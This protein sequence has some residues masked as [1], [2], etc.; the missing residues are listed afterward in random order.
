MLT[1]NPAS[2]EAVGATTAELKFF[3]MMPGVTGTCPAGTHPIIHLYHPTYKTHF[4]TTSV[5][6]RDAMKRTGWRVAIQGTDPGLLNACI[7]AKDETSCD[8]LPLMRVTAAGDPTQWMNATTSVREVRDCL[9]TV[10]VSPATKSCSYKPASND[11]LGRVW[12]KP[13]AYVV[14]Q[15]LDMTG[16]K[17]I[18][19]TLGGGTATAVARTSGGIDEVHPIP[20]PADFAFSYQGVPIKYY[21]KASSN[22]LI[23]FNQPFMDKDDSLADPHDLPA[24]KPPFRQVSGWWEPS[25]LVND[26]TLLWEMQGTAPNRRLV[27][28]WGSPKEGGWWYTRDRSTAREMQIHLVESSNRI[29]VHYGEM[30]TVPGSTASAAVGMDDVF[31]VDG[32]QTACS[33]H[34]GVSDWKLEG[35]TAFMPS[36]R[37]FGAFEEWPVSPDTTFPWLTD[38]TPGVH[39]EMTGAKGLGA[40]PLGGNFPFDGQIFQTV[41]IATSGHLRLGKTATLDSH[42]DIPPDPADRGIA[43]N[44]IA[45]W[46][47]ENLR[48]G[49]D[50]RGIK[51]DILTLQIDK[52]PDGPEFVV[53]W[54]NL[55]NVNDTLPTPAT[56]QMQVRLRATDGSIIFRYG[57]SSFV[58]PGT[59]GILPLLVDR[60]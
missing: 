56:R 41:S 54:N 29:E 51:G 42:A 35:V 6:E 58:N 11:T 10:D 55:V 36:P 34:C 19:S 3:A 44:I 20:L 24:R 39:H 30:I 38:A 47:D 46:W 26:T 60:I 27:I 59:G 22:G 12:A 17:R 9:P 13:P 14:R 15:Y 1:N 5:A 16:Y 7:A 25:I 40:M 37:G 18:V 33:P 52:G 2:G 48:L 50:A 57:H 53:Q 32:V 8:L 31:G 43:T 45:P 4:Y 49:N 28:Q 23:T 21:L